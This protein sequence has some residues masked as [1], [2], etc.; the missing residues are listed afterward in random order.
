M[1]FVA[2]NAM[3][4]PRMMVVGLGLVAILLA[5]GAGAGFWST[6]GHRHEAIA[7]ALTGGEP[8]RAPALIRRYGCA[9]CHTISAVQGADGK[10][11]PALDG[12][13]QRVYIGGVLANSPDNLVQWIVSPK[14]F[15]PRTAMPATGIREAEARDVAAFLYAH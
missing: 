15:S 4:H 6:S 8:W 11:A 14:L 13:L 5:A 3:L 7:K 2:R 10:V 12:L 1:N 9:G